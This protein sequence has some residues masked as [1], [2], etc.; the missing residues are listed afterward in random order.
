MYSR[1]TYEESGSYTITPPPGY[2]GSRFRRRSDGRDDNFPPYDAPVP[3]IEGAAPKEKKDSKET[4]KKSIG[5][6]EL[7][8]VALIIALASEEKPCIELILMLALLLC[9]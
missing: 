3:K 5:G 8:I 4:R 9:T 2:D 1:K 7:L 6:E